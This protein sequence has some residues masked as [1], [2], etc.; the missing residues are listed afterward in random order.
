MSIRFTNENNSL[1]R[2][3]YHLSENVKMFYYTQIQEEITNKG[4]YSV[5]K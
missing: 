4:P 5:S 3:K 2:M 1:R